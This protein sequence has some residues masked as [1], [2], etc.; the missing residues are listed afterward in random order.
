MADRV[1]IM[2]NRLAT[3]HLHV[4]G[5]PPIQSAAQPLGPARQRPPNPPR[6]AR[7]TFRNWRKLLGPGLATKRRH[8]AQ[9]VNPRVGAASPHQLHRLAHH[10]PHRAFDHLLNAAKLHPGSRL[11]FVMNGANHGEGQ[12]T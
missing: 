12:G 8:L 7:I 2:V 6:H 1:K 9:G 5:Q 3:Q 10:L 11:A 4:V